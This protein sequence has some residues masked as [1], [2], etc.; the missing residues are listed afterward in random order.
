MVSYDYETVCKI[1]VS[2]LDEGRERWLDLAKGFLVQEQ[3]LS[4]RE[5]INERM[6]P[7][8]DIGVP[9][10]DTPDDFPFNHVSGE[11]VEAVLIAIQLSKV[12]EFAMDREYIDQEALSEIFKQLVLLTKDRQAWVF[13][14]SSLTADQQINAD[15][16]CRVLTQYLLNERMVSLRVK[17]VS[18]RLAEGI[19]MLI[20]FAV[21]GT[22]VAFGDE[23]TAQAIMAKLRS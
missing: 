14:I 18:A 7:K 15:S 2:Q 21:L 6:N 8:I 11:T 13:G 10:T 22:A 16:A 9:E 20:G 12:I 19:P 5:I 17:L 4:P 3:V 23:T 1:L